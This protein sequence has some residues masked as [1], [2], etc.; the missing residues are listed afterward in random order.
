VVKS[1]AEMFK[2]VQYMNIL[3]PTYP[4]GMIGLMVCSTGPDFSA[5]RR[6]V[7]EEIQ[8]ELR[9][10]TPEVHEAAFRLPRFAAMRIGR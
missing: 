5:P 9:Y 4:S 10:Y 6:P 8:R 1:T 3:V 2:H 7:P